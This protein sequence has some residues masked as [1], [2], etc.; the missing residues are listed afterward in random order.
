[1]AL[2]A[3]RPEVIV[4]WACH[5]CGKERCFVSD[6]ALAVLR[7][8]THRKNTRTGGDQLILADVELAELRG[9]GAE[10]LM[11]KKA[12]SS[13]NGILCLVVLYTHLAL[14]PPRGK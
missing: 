4:G 2:L 11:A 1:M 12:R 7:S 10:T 9:S 6:I 8:L 14:S 5:A 3:N 13:R